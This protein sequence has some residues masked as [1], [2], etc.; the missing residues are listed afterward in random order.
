[1]GPGVGC[2]PSAL[3][4]G[5]C[6]AARG[7]SVCRRLPCQSILHAPIRTP[8]A[9]T[10]TSNAR[11]HA[12]PRYA[13]TVIHRAFYANNKLGD[14]RIS[15]REFR[16]CAKRVCVAAACS[17]V[18]RLPALRLRCRHRQ[19]CGSPPS[20]ALPPPLLH[21]S[22]RPPFTPLCPAPRSCLQGRHPGGAARGGR[23][24]GHQQGTPLMFNLILIS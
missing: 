23:A 10:H 12:P 4:P 2:G 6:R 21:C 16:R 5:C 18:A 9:P 22:C 13:E 17:P 15:W 20:S 8:H 14:G 3:L 7:S 24:G 19:R 11:P 1:M